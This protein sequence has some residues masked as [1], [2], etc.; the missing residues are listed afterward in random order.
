[1]MIVAMVAVAIITA[2]LLANLICVLLLFWNAFWRRG[3]TN[4]R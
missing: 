3:G 4:A 1:M 2:W